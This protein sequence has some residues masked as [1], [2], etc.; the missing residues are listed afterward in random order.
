MTEFPDFGND[1]TPITK[2]VFP[3]GRRFP[4]TE[5][6]YACFRLA[7]YKGFLSAWEVFSSH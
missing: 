7:Y 1:K 5:L 6:L 3:C 2:T 4:L